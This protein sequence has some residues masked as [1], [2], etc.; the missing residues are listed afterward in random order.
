MDELQQR[1][2]IP[3]IKLKFEL[4]FVEDCTLPKDKVSAL[5]GGM[6]EM[7]LQ[8][9][10]IG[11]RNCE[12]CN[13]AKECIVYRTL[14]TPMKRMPPFMQ[15]LNSIGY[16]I[17]CENSGTVFK[18][19][20]GFFFYLVLFGKSMSFF[21]QY[22]M[23]FRQLGSFG[24]GKYKARYLIG[25]I[26][27]ANNI[28]I[29]HNN[30][31]L[32]ANYQPETIYEYAK[33]RREELYFRGYDNEIV[34]HTPLTLKYQGEYIQEFCTEAI[35]QAIFRRIMMLDY[36]VENYIEQPKPE[37]YP[38]IV[39]QNT[40]MRTITRFSTAKNASI[41]LHGIVGTV[42]FEQIPQEYL[43]YILGGELLHI[44]KNSSFGF[45]RYS[46]Q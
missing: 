9:N 17:E 37:S 44:G 35:F 25:D 45:G 31:I 2:S 27:N 20:N 3:Y 43:L 34:F 15:G 32:T 42:R 22:Y 30:Q 14:Y 24:I 1:L 13:F 10:C 33:R 38:V 4:I 18:S 23:A 29:L 46:F 7:L 5:R 28:S 6:G 40:F 16:L 26:K 21:G 11:N 39:E 12:S 36:F 19:G 41:H 8:Q